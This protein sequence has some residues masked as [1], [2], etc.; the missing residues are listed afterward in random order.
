MNEK[1]LQPRLGTH[2]VRDSL[3]GPPSQKG[4]QLVEVSQ[5][6]GRVVHQAFIYLINLI[7]TIKKSPAARKF[8]KNKNQIM[9][10]AVIIVGFLLGLFVFALFLTVFLVW[11]II[12]S[13]K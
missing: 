6:E 2:Y 11:R 5:V 7:K 12:S 10:R 4:G 1:S 8:N 3:R 13:E 9:I